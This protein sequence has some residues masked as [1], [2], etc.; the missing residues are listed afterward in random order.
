MLGD[1]R[2]NSL[3]AKEPPKPE[4]PPVAEVPDEETEDEANMTSAVPVL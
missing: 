3:F 2:S 1:R 4:L